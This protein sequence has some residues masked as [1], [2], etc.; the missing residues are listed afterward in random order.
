MTQLLD[1]L[2]EALRIELQQYGEILAL[3]DLQHEAVQLQGAEEV[4]RTVA[5]IH[6]QSAAI[7]AARAARQHWQRQVALALGESP[8]AGLAQLAARMPEPYRLLV[9]ALVREN[10]ELRDRA[11]DQ[12]EQNQL[13]LHKA[14]QLLEQ[15]LRTLNRPV[16][17]GPTEPDAPVVLE[18]PTDPTPQRAIA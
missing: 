17:C 10:N 11:R 6:A 18:A 3:L 1:H 9:L 4:L 12:A 5:A 15:F 16:A 7:E 14:V 8:E 2:I 13:L